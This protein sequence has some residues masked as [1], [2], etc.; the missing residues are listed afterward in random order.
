[1][2]YFH[3]NTFSF[4]KNVFKG[5]SKETSF[6]PL[7]RLSSDL[8]TGIYD[9]NIFF[10]KVIPIIVLYF[11]VDNT[12]PKTFLTFLLITFDLHLIPF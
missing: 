3:F 1:M 4:T 11:S 6:H 2:A 12:H 10:Y 7:Y 8:Y 5:A 9:R